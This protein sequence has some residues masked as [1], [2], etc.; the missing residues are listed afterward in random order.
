[1]AI[2]E[3][4]E[5]VR[6]TG[7]RNHALKIAAAGALSVLVIILMIRTLGEID[8]AEVWAALER[9]PVS[10]VVASALF[11]ALSLAA[12]ARYDALSLGQ[13]GYHVPEGKALSGGFMAVGLGQ[14]LGF[15]LLVG[16]F[17]RWR[18]YRGYGVGPAEAGFLSGLIAAG[19]FF[20]FAIV[21]AVSAWLDP[22]G[23]AFLTGFSSGAVR[24]I[25]VLSMLLGAAVYLLSMLQV[26][27]RVK[28]RE[29]RLPPVR[30]LARQFT[31]A[32]FDTI[33][34]ALALWVLIPADHGISVLAFIPVYLAALGVGLFSN[35]PGGLGALELACIMALPVVPVETLVAAL[36][37]HRAI[38]YGA[39]ALIAAA[40]LLNREI[41]AARPGAERM[42]VVAPGAKGSVPEAAEALLSRSVRADAG[43]AYTGETHFLFSEDRRA[44]LAYAVEGNSLIA[45]SDPIGDRRAWPELFRAFRD[46]ADGMSR[47]PVFY[48]VSE[49]AAGL[50]ALSGFGVARCGVEGVIDVESFTLEGSERRELRR[51]LRSAEKACI[52]FA[53]HEPGDMPDATIREVAAAWSKANGPARGFSMGEADPD[54][55]RNF[56]IIE[57]RQHG[58]TV[59]FLSVWMS[60][61]GKDAGLD[62]M[63]LKPGAPDGTMHGLVHAGLLWARDERA[64]TFGLGAV[65]FAGIDA[66]GSLVERALAWI[67]DE[68]PAWHGA[69]GLMRFKSIFRPDWRVRYSAAPGS[70]SLAMGLWDTKTRI[71][72]PGR[73]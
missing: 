49:P 68:K 60:G 47:A 12:V 13:L 71:H 45:L 17:V 11:S 15:G 22:T 20:A 53:Y 59:G 41:Q 43:L 40:M 28:G 19:F 30:L 38:Y 66:P 55:L 10:A 42:S 63:R 5:G 34:A 16:S 70:L 14:A 73:R 58:E 69:H 8:G 32:A 9:M 35:T 1:M 67:Y 24:W 62:V 57:A 61:D 44:M 46:L 36:I 65:P 6:G 52:V 39:P 21:L 37:A 3:T 29:L 23:I 64:E 4:V 51:K 7:R 33:P 27:I 72:A 2:S 54:Y 25:A 26:P 48:K 18:A 31:L 56:A 50:L